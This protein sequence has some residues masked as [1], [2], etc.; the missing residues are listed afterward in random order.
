[1]GGGPS[2]P[3]PYADII[4]DTIGEGNEVATGIDGEYL[5]LV[6]LCV[7][8]VVLLSVPCYNI[9]DFL[10]SWI[11]TLYRVSFM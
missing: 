8:R 3:P 9:Q 11:I 1:M 2:R 5:H 7:V 6:E 4:M 10:S